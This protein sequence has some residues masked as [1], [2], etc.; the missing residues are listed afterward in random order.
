MLS[1][2]QTYYLQT[3]GI[4]PWVLRKSESQALITV[5]LDE[6]IC[7]VNQKK[8]FCA[9]FQSIVL[10]EEMLDVVYALNADGFKQHINKVKPQVIVALGHAAGKNLFNN[11]ATLESMRKHVH[12]YEKTHVIVTYHPLDLLQDPID[13]KEA[14]RDLALVKAALSVFL[15][16]INAS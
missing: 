16:K 14:Y 15:D 1:N 9:M 6:K 3:M 13:K 7:D 2:L 5:L 8:L 11:H 4:E 10:P 12:A